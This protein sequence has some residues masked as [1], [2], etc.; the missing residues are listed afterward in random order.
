MN[1]L[2]LPATK[3]FKS[4]VSG[5]KP[6]ATLSTFS[7]RPFSSRPQKNKQQRFPN[8]RLR[9]HA[10]SFMDGDYSDFTDKAHEEDAFATDEEWELA[11]MN[12]DQE[13]EEYLARKQ[14]EQEA[15]KYQQE[16]QMF[17]LVTPS[18]AFEKFDGQLLVPLL[19]LERMTFQ[20][21]QLLTDLH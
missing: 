5:S 17:A 19:S 7:S 9:T 6:A 3:M 16:E 2:R 1:Q 21:F 11:P 4:L 12:D 10:I 18:L 20:S 13:D 14:A 8:P 15:L